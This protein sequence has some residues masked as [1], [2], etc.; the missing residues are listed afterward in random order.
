LNGSWLYTN[1]T[2]AA[3][4][5]ALIA[6]RALFARRQAGEPMA[7]ILGEREFFGLPFAVTPVVL[8]PRPETELLAELAR[9]HLPERG[10][11]LD[12]GTGSGA[13][14]IAIAHMRPDAEVWACDVS[15]AALEVARGNAARNQVKVTF[16][17]SDGLAA[18]GDQRF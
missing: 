8:I 16:V 6:T 14:A 15:P 11:L 3:P 4:P 1:D 12:I 17:E 18:L 10:R 2:D 7:Y 9:A 5:A 13:I